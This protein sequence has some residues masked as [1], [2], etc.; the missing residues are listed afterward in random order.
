MPKYFFHT[1]K[2]NYRAKNL[3]TPNIGPTK[4]HVFKLCKF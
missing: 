2:K 3:V 1:L 4:I